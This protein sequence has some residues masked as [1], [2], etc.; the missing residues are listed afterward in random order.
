MLPLVEWLVLQLVSYLQQIV[1]NPLIRRADS[2]D[3]HTDD[4]SQMS[5]LIARKDG[6]T[7]KGKN[8]VR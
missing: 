8:R 4:I 1:A 3:F 2:H 7:F 6:I 5:H